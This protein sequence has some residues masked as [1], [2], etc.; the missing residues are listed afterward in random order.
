MAITYGSSNQFSSNSQWYD[1]AALSSSAYVVVYYDVGAAELRAVVCTVSGTTI[2]LNTPVAI[3]GASNQQVAIDVLDSTHFV[4]NFRDTGNSGNVIVGSISGTT[5]TFGTSITI[6]SAGAG[7]GYRGVVALSSSLF[8]A[9][10]YESGGGG[11]G[12]AIACT[13]SGTTI[14]SGTKVSMGANVDLSYYLTPIKISSTSFAV[15]HRKIA[16]F[17]GE[18]ILGS[19]SGTTITLGTASNFSTGDV[20]SNVAC[21]PIDSTH[22]GISWVD[23]SNNGVSLVS[24]VSGT[25]I[26]SFGSKYNW[27]TDARGMDVTG[28]DSTHF[29]IS[30]NNSTPRASNTIGTVSG[31]T[32]TYDTAIVYDSSDSIA[33]SGGARSAIAILDTTHLVNAWVPSAGSAAK[34][35]IGEFTLSGGSSARMSLLG[36]GR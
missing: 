25:T 7:T 22:V 27:T 23:A 10:S 8:V 4:V 3:S 32:I 28:I 9:T 16:S 36:V 12:Y 33:T 2:T 31:T 14:T 5:I 15:A 29:V 30:S 26:S 6:T 20:G 11:T 1:V 35:I 21:F 17:D 34:T 24:V 13:V 19:V 18:L